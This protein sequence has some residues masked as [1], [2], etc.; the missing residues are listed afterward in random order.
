MPVPQ[1][2]NLASFGVD[3]HKSKRT[4]PVL[5]IFMEKRFTTEPSSIRKPAANLLPRPA[6]KACAL[7]LQPSSISS[8]PLTKCRR[9]TYLQDIYPVPVASFVGQTVFSYTLY[10]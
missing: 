10:V 6:K 3:S 2:V 7:R 9:A 1:P 4:D 8:V 5:L